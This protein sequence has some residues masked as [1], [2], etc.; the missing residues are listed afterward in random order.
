MVLPDISDLP[1]VQGVLHL[2]LHEWIL[3][4]PRLKKTYIAGGVCKIQER[5]DWV[6]Q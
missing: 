5:K 6:N 1:K 4:V 3:S 2:I